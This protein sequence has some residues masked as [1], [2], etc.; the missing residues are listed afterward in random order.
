VNDSES[1]YSKPISLGVGEQ[2]SGDLSNRSDINK[3]GKVNLVDFSILLSAWGE[4]EGDADINEDGRINL[5][6]VSILLFNW[7]G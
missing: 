7:T 3:D 6:D 5:A 2:A 4:T 1:E